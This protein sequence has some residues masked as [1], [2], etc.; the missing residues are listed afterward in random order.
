MQ[1]V[2]FIFYFILF[3]FTISFIPFFRNSG[4]GRYSLIGLFSI[5]VLAGFA[6]AKFFAQP[7][8]LEGADT[9]RFYGQSLSETKWLLKNPVAFTKDLFLYGYS[10]PGNLF[11]GVN[12]YWNDLKSNIVVKMMAVINVVTNNSYYVNI[13]FFNFL[14][15]FGLVALFRLLNQIFPNRYWLI[16]TGIFL[17]PGTLFWCSGIHKDGLILSAT[18]VIIY[19]FNRLLENKG[20]AKNVTAVLL[21]LLLVFALRNYVVLMLVPALFAWSLSTKFPEKKIIVFAVIYL[22]AICL[23]FLV[24]LIIPALN[25]P[26]FVTRKQHEFLLL[27][28]GSKVNVQILQ[29]DIKSFISF[30]P[31]ALDMAFLRPHFSEIRNISYI[32]AAVEIVLLMLLLVYCV[33]KINKKSIQPI[34][35]F[36]L[37]FSVSILLLAGYTI[38]FTSAIVRYRSFAWPFLI[39]P[40][41][42]IAGAGKTSKSL[43][44]RPE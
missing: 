16:I 32:P 7:Q 34:V 38:P 23:F 28:G 35:L 33:L 21:G 22:A 2:L 11:S 1:L 42:C 12:T 27:Q 5:K 14:F 37:F 13:V 6:Y 25:L 9:W 18:G 3:S 29:P 24:P 44:R 8:Y 17:L 20:F 36:F 26:E 43:N 31:T 39:T 4:I 15:L 30:F 10:S 40:L 19:A 41:L